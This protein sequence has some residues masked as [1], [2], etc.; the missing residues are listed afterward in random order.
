MHKDISGI[1]E[2]WEYNPYE[3]NVRVIK[4]N[5]GKEKLQLRLDLGL[6]QMEMNGRPDGKR[7][8]D[9]DSYY[10][11][12]K[13]LVDKHTMKTGSDEGFK[14]DVED[15]LKLQQEALQFYHRYLC[16]F[17]IED[18]ERAERDTTRNLKVVS[19]VEKYG[20]NEEEVWSLAQY[21][22]YIKMMNT[23]AKASL[24]LRQKGYDEALK[25]IN[26]GI[27]QIKEFL[28]EHELDASSDSN[29][30]LLFLENWADSVVESK[31]LSFKEKLLKKLERAISRQE[32]EKAAKIRD[33][34]KSIENME[35]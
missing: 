3:I 13:K 30:E 5:N 35:I 24:V 2:G 33:Q 9:S 19:F 32:Y 11:H 1:L 22:P 28:S 25:I 15:L 17:Q 10:D 23:R 6:L 34:L 31:P 8:L 12:Y 16:F 20:D 29:P 18:F 27:E 26:E 14:L 7:P 21:W 4:G